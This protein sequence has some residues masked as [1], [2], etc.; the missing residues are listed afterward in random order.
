[1]T[2]LR[3]GVRPNISGRW[4]VLALVGSGGALGAWIG[5]ALSG[6]ALGVAVTP[7][8]FLT[9]SFLIGWSNAASP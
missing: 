2:I 5:H 6:N 8:L 7:W 3:L 4:L 9:L 1:M